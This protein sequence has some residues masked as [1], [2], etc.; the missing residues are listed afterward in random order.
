MSLRGAAYVAICASLM[1]ASPASAVEPVGKATRIKTEVSGSQ[2]PIVVDESIF[3]DERIRTSADGLGQF[4][5]NDGTKLAVGWGSTVTIDK[6][7]YDDSKTVKKLTLKAAKGTF[8]WVSGRSKS[9]AYDIVTPAGTIGVRGTAFD[10]YIG[11]DGTTA[12]VLLG[13]AATFCGS[14][15]CRRLTSRCDC[16]VAK[17]GQPTSQVR[18]VDRTIFTRLRSSRAL[19]FLTGNQA[20]SGGLGWIS[21]CGLSVATES[22]RQIDRRVTTPERAKAPAKPAPDK[23][24]PNKPEKPDK[25][26]KPD[27]GKPDPG[28]PGPEGPS[29]P[30][31]D[32]GKPGKEGSRREGSR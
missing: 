1:G 6:F 8:R 29:K 15:G 30:G 7:V 17:R 12:V 23:P 24:A 31:G 2:G 9:S 3:K 25:P 14:D 32:T 28:K 22:P 4:S 19:P 13:G 11:P 18:K 21:G 5:F 27:P 26:D 16:V 20:L 10:F